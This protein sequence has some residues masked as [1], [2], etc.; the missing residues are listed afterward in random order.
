M[1][2]IEFLSSKVALKDYTQVIGAILLQSSN[3]QEWLEE[4]EGGTIDSSRHTTRSIRNESI[5]E[6][7]LDA[8]IRGGRIISST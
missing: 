6:H 4:V 1:D 2:D 3:R 7:S 8:L 5:G